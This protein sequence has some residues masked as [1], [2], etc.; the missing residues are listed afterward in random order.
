VVRAFVFPLLVGAATARA[1]PP[2]ADA[3][4]LGVRVG[5]ARLFQGGWTW[6]G[7]ATWSTPRWRVH[8]DTTS[9]GFAE[10][11]AREQVCASDQP[12][13]TVLTR[14]RGSLDVERAWTRDARRLGVGAVAGA[15]QEVDEQC[16]PI[17]F[18]DGTG[19]DVSGLDFR[20]LDALRIRG[21]LTASA[22]LGDAARGL[23]LRLAALAQ[24]DQTALVGRYWVTTDDAAAGDTL[25]DEET[26]VRDARRWTLA[27]QAALTGRLTL[28]SGD[29]QLRGE[30][31]SEVFERVEEQFDWSQALTV[32]AGQGASDFELQETHT[33]AVR[34]RRVWEVRG[35]AEAVFLQRRLAGFGLRAWGE[36]GRTTALGGATAVSAGAGFRY[37]AGG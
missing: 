8:G 31:A 37:G 22:A 25:L 12:G 26:S 27:G 24:H 14:S 35:R 28:L 18:Q 23:D 10:N 30:A 29:L 5:S 16:E 36:V 3:S 2:T 19:R 33:Y 1:A 4:P 11:R 20:Q 13:F 17:G 6:D 7:G 21:G 9:T 34:Q 32:A 15:V